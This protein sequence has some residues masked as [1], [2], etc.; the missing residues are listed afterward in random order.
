MKNLACKFALFGLPAREEVTV[1]PCRW[2]EP[3]VGILIFVRTGRPISVARSSRPP[4]GVPTRRIAKATN[5]GLGYSHWY[6]RPLQLA[7]GR[8]RRKLS[9]RIETSSHVRR[10]RSAGAWAASD[11]VV[12]FW[13]WIRCFEKIVDILLGLARSPSELGAV[14]DP[15]LDVVVAG[16]GFGFESLAGFLLGWARWWGWGGLSPFLGNS[17]GILW[18]VSQ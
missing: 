5:G 1:L 14:V 18:E 8:L 6:P 15:S 9:T 3:K 10:E 17:V 4:G 12:G 16:W 11:V 2:R 7:P 13:G